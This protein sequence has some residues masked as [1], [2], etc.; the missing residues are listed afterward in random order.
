MA[1]SNQTM[2]QVLAG[3]PFGKVKVSEMMKTLKVAK[4]HFGFDLTKVHGMVGA[5]RYVNISRTNN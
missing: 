3:T 1:R 4:H 5:L 2:K